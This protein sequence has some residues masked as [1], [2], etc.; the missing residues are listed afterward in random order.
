MLYDS[1]KDK[2]IV[3]NSDYLVA[4]SK[5]L[6]DTI[7]DR[8]KVSVKP[9]RFLVVYGGSNIEKYDSLTGRDLRDELN[10]PKDKILVA[11]IG[12]FKTLGTTKGIDMMIEALSYLPENV[13]MVFVGGKH[14]EIEEIRAGITD[15]KIRER[16]IFVERQDIE[17][18]PMYQKAVDILVIPSPDKPPFSN[19]LLPMKVYEY[20]AS[21]KPIVYSDLPILR[22]VLGGCGFSFK[23]GDSKDLAG[24]ITSINGNPEVVKQKTD[25]C[26]QLAKQTTWDK[27]AQ[28][29]IDFL[30]K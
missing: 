25:L 14:E 4:T 5:R 18:V 28:N 26:Y 15:P 23:P 19:Y 1:W 9:D 30:T 16:V 29:V 3:K 7:L 27:R 12:M 20:I 13:S 24:V 10:L 11:Y 21:K 2:F 17:R 6:C 22:E 8:T